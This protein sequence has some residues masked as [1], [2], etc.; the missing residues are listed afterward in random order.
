LYQDCQITCILECFK[1]AKIIRILPANSFEK[2]IIDWLGFY[3]NKN[4]VEKFKEKTVD[5]YSS[6]LTD[7]R[8]LDIQFGH[9]LN[10]EQFDQTYDQIVNHLDLPYK[11]IRFDLIEFWANHQHE[12]IRPMLN[13]I[14]ERTT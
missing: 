3:K 10:K 9:L 4:I 14:N 2:N 5:I 11:L 6:T 13:K 12:I 1:Q 7:N 8:L